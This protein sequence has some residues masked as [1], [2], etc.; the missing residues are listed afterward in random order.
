MIVGFPLFT[1]EIAIALDRLESNAH[2]STSCSSQL[3]TA[4][5]LELIKIVSLF[6]D[7][8]AGFE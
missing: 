5:I 4:A 2:A 3:V 8:D 1:L 6:A 7:I